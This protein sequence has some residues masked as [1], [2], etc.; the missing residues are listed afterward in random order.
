MAI[1]NN[2]RIIILACLTLGLAPYFPEP[3]VLG[4]LKWILGGAKGMQL[5]DWFDF[6]LHGSPFLLLIRIAV[7]SIRKSKKRES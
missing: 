1:L 4:K 5:M 2:W 7:I 3:H 6:I